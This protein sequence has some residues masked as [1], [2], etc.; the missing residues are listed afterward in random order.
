MITI[1]YADLPEGLHA[2][3]E[4]RGRRTVIYL[5]PGLTA[6]QRRLSLRRARQSARMGHGP[7]LPAAGVVQA[8]ARDSVRGSVGTMGA[9]LRRHPLGAAPLAAGL[10]GMVACYALFATGSIRLVLHQAPEP[11]RPGSPQPA[12]VLRP[13]APDPGPGQRRHRMRGTPG[14]TPHGH[15]ARRKHPAAPSQRPAAPG[16][17]GSRGPSSPAAAPST[18]ATPPPAPSPRPSEVCLYVGPL[19]VCVPG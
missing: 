13:P 1:R 17:P 11:G 19:R 5:R 8:V 7:R 2:R 15:A 18:S 14:S 16:R 9:V 6:E 10:G 12:V 3:A 4:R